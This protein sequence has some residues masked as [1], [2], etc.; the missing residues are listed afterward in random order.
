MFTFLVILF[1]VKTL[2][3]FLQKKENLKVAF[4]LVYHICESLKYLCVKLTALDLEYHPEAISKSDNP[5]VK[6]HLRVNRELDKY[7][8]WAISFS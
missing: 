3:H 6:K 7:F 2:P 5:D 8:H 1:I 4:D